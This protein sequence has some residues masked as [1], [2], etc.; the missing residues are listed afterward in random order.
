MIVIIADECFKAILHTAVIIR[1]L[2]ISW[3]I[4]GGRKGHDLSPIKRTSC[5]HNVERT[6][7]LSREIFTGKIADY[8]S[9]S[10]IYPIILILL[11]TGKHKYHV[12]VKKSRLK[13]STFQPVIIDPA[14]PPKPLAF[15]LKVCQAT[16]RSQSFRMIWSN[17]FASS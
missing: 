13:I 7:Y 1:R 16:V 3:T 9:K 4:N 6:F 12:A 15:Y 14:R 8:A 2:R 17:C 5:R 10:C 11:T